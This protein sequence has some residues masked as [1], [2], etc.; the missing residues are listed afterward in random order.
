MKANEDAFVDPKLKA[1]GIKEWNNLREDIKLIKN[2]GLYEDKVAGLEK[3]YKD[4]I[5]K[6]GE[7]SPKW[8]E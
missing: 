7:K 8:R 4:L 1:E 2:Q 3:R 5:E 6:Y